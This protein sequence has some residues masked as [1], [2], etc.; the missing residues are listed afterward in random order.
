MMEGK[1]VTTCSKKGGLSLS[2]AITLGSGE[3]M[4]YVV[5]ARALALFQTL[6]VAIRYFW[7]SEDLKSR[8]LRR[9]CEGCMRR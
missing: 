2:I 4:S 1:D 9:P 5:K 8:D 6:R 3:A 7:T